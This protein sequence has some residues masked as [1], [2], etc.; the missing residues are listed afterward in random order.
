VGRTIMR[1][2]GYRIRKGYDTGSIAD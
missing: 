2:R 1:C